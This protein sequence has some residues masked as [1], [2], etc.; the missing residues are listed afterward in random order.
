MKRSDRDLLTKRRGG[1]KHPKLGKLGA[2]ALDWAY[3]KLGGLPV[4]RDRIERQYD[5]LLDSVADSLRPYRQEFPVFHELPRQ[6]LGRPA[7]LETLRA[8]SERERARWHGGYVSGAVYHGDEGHIDFQNEVYAL[9]SQANPLHVDIW[10]SAIKYEAEVVAMTARMLGAPAPEGSADT[11]R[12]G[13]TVT[14]GG[15]ESILL[16]LKAYR[17]RAR[18]ERGFTRLSVIA[19][20][21]AH[22]AF[23]KAA[24]LLDI[25]VNRV[26]VGPD[27]RADVAAMRRAIS[28]RTIAIAASAP[29]FPHGVIDPIEEIA[30]LALEHQLGFHVDACLGAFILPWARRLGYPVPDFDFRIPG[31]TSMS[32]DTHKYGFAAKGTSVVLYR[33]TALRRFQYFVNADWPGGL[34][35]SP[36]LAG[37]RP[38]ALGA[39]CWASLV[40]LGESGYL[41]AASRILQTAKAIRQGIED[42]PDLYVLGDP[43]WVI[44]FSART[45]DIYRVL[46]ALSERGWSLNGLQHPA[47]IHLCVALPHTQPGV[48]DRFLSDLR[49]AVDQVRGSARSPGGLAPIYGLSGTFPVRGAVRELLRRY[50]DRLYDL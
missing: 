6:G 23:D 1:D 41:E 42:I 38:G 16:A 9:A 24:E 25:E 4:I 37:S 10:P 28:P 33:G 44:A 39:A 18:K 3:D 22:A 14:S 15:T 49:S 19:P 13:G 26:P 47:S 2:R 50:I 11:E 46:D 29:G 32:A 17:D 34:Y 31:V 30:E 36:T 43:L 35:F 48:A 12:V 5:S 8:L 20:D 40:S 21:S 45:L 27:F 7:V